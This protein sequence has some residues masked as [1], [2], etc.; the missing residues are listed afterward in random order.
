MK[1]VLGLFIM[2]FA[3]CFVTGCSKSHSVEE[4]R[5][6]VNDAQKVYTDATSVH[7]T[8]DVNNGT[9]NTHLEVQYDYNSGKTALQDMA[10]V[11]TSNGATESM[12]VKEGVAY[13]DRFGQKFTSQINDNQ[14][15]DIIDNYGFAAFTHSLFKVLGPSFFESAS[16]ISDK[17]D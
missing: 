14:V 10:Y 8:L 7:Y 5:Q 16:V 1:K 4:I 9:D 6:M 13:M 15:T 3:L 12:Y 11:L 17:T 2:L